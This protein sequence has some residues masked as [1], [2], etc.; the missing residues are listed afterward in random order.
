MINDSSHST[1]VVV[2]GLVGGKI[3]YQKN[4]RF[5]ANLQGA[6]GLSQDQ[7]STSSVTGSVYDTKG[8]FSGALLFFIV[9]ENRKSP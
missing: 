9:L 1:T 7:L 4:E 8:S 2:A 6:E 5:I 3:S